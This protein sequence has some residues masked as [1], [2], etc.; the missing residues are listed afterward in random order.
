MIRL[1]SQTV[2]LSDDEMLISEIVEVLLDQG[3]SQGDAV[4][5]IRGSK[6]ADRLR[7]PTPFLDQVLTP[8]FT[9]YLCE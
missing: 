4:I 9:S 5:L 1:D 3:Y 8:E 7:T 2:E 6:V